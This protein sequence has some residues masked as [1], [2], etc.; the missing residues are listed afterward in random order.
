MVL[1]ILRAPLVAACHYLLKPKLITFEWGIQAVIVGIAG[2]RLAPRMG[3]TGA[4]LA[5]LFGSAMAF[6]L[7]SYV[8]AVSWRAAAKVAPA[9]NRQTDP[10]PEA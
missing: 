6:V 9:S 4:A 3:A 8:I 10:F 1:T 7:L 2:L 5:Q